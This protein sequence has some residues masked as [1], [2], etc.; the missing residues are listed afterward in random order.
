ME[1]ETSR[2]SANIQSDM[3]SNMLN[4]HEDMEN[5]EPHSLM[6]IHKEQC[7]DTEALLRK[8][9]TLSIQSSD[10][11]TEYTS[12]SIS[13]PQKQSNLPKFRRLTNLKSFDVQREIVTET[14]TNT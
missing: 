6:D 3:P 4:S 9:R 7:G 1:Q 10:T 2:G 11:D 5:S 8:T 12:T 13:S 14:G